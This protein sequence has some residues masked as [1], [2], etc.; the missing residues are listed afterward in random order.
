MICSRDLSITI[1]P[2]TRWWWPLEAVG[3][4]VDV[5][6]GVTASQVGASTFTAPAGK[7][8]NGALITK[9]AFDFYPFGF[10]TAIIP[11]LAYDAADGFTFCGWARR[12]SGNTNDDFLCA[13]T[14]YADAGGVTANGNVSM[15]DAVNIF[16][17]SA[18]GT[19]FSIC[20]TN[21]AHVVGLGT[22]FFFAVSYRPSD[23]RIVFQVNNGP[24]Q[25]S[26]CSVVI[27]SSPFGQFRF[28]YGPIAAA[29]SAQYDE[30]ALFYPILTQAQIDYIFNSGAGRTP[31][32]TL[33]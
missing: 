6:S 33:P 11:E 14:L 22:F 12:V 15:T 8:S 20:V 29:G 24:V 25:T 32:I 7:V 28:F 13:L 10:R 4:Q 5:L 26:A 9:T 2:A 21:V 3:A 23:G 31:P 18:S 1:E 27:P 30:V 16:E 19:P 17:T